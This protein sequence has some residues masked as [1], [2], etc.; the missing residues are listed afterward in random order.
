[1]LQ[2]KIL[3]VDDNKGIRSFLKALLTPEG[4]KVFLISNAFDAIDTASQFMPDLIIMDLKMPCLS[5]LEALYYFKRSMPDIPIILL[6]G[7]SNMELLEKVLAIDPCIVFVRK[8]FDLVSIRELV[9]EKLRGSD[10][11]L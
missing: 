10:I 4:Y 2:K 6:S 7:Y 11:S 8:P 9:R 3:V 1:M 5:G